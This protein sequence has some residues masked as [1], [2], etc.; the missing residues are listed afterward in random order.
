MTAAVLSSELHLPLHTILMD[1]LVTKFMGETSA[2]LRQIFDIIQSRKGVYL[3]DEF[4]AIGAEKKLIPDETTSVWCE[5]WLLQE[6]DETESQFRSLAQLLDIECD[7]GAL[8]FP[9][10]LV[11]LIKA[12]W[13]QLVELIEASPHI[14]EFR[15]AKETALFWTELPNAEQTQWVR[16]LVIRLSVDENT[17]V[18]VC[19]LDTGANNGHELL[20]PILSDDDCQTYHPDWGSHDHNSHGT[21]MCGVAAY[22]DLQKALESNHPVTLTHK[23]ESVKILPPGKKTK[24]TQTLRRNHST[25]NVAC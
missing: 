18:S 16:D 7:E 17:K 24:R 2:K 20:Q 19:V 10:R 3:F 8:Q 4:D 1:K 11:V 14:A 23:L 22:G 25:S 21:L 13:K 9:E 6:N 15:R 5:V 12:N